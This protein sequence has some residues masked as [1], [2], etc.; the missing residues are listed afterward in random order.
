MASPAQP[1]A[2]TP[3]ST[4][5]SATAATMSTTAATTSTLDADTSTDLALASANT[6]FDALFAT[7]TADACLAFNSGSATNSGTGEQSPF[8]LL[9]LGV[10]A[11]DAQVLLELTH[12]LSENYMGYFQ[13]AN[14]KFTK[15]FKTVFPNGLPDSSTT[16]SSTIYS[17]TSSLAV[18]NGNLMTL[19]PSAAASTSTLASIS[20]SISIST[21][22]SEGSTLPPVKSQLFWR[23]GA[24]AI[25]GKALPRP[26][27]LTCAVH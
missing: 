17:T 2:S 16:S 24:S 23:W 12:A 22:T 10:A 25:W 27:V 1:L 6:S 21:P 11:A 26:L 20:I 13:S 3:L 19:S 8:H 4:S 15:I 18:A 5:S 9:C 14:S 7:R